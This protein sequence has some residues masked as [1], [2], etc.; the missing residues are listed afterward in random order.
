[1]EIL[2]LMTVLNIVMLFVNAWMRI[3]SEKMLGE[4]KSGFDKGGKIWTEEG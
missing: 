2:Y 4:I 3:G 1:M